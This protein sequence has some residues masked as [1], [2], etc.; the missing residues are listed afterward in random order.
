MNPSVDHAGPRRLFEVRVISSENFSDYTA[1]ALKVSSGGSTWQI[2]KRYSEFEAFNSK[3]RDRFP[4]LALP[5]LPGKVWF[6]SMSQGVVEHRKQ[7]AG[8]PLR[9]LLCSHTRPGAARLFGRA[10]GSQRR[11]PV[12]GYPE[13]FECRRAQH[14][15]QA[16]DSGGRAARLY[17]E[18]AN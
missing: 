8:A 4:M 7:V 12:P 11:V 6:G 17:H 1:Y 2:S 9:P 14:G 15:H 16:R 5:K 13:I 18:Y 10:H 3:L